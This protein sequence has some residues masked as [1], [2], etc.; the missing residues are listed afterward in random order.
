MF[1]YPTNFLRVTSCCLHRSI[2]TVPQNVCG[3]H[4]SIHIS[5]KRSILHRT[6]HYRCFLSN[7]PQNIRSLNMSPNSLNM[8]HRQIVGALRLWVR[9]G[10]SSLR[11]G[12]LDGHLYPLKCWSDMGCNSLA[13]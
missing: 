2:R 6:C 11:M 5:H 13:R 4:V 12:S 8:L 3:P 7:M 1:P 9:T 10:D